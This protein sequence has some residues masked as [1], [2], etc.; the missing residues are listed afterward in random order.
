[1][2]RLQLPLGRK[3]LGR[4][5]PGEVHVAEELW[6]KLHQQ[7][8]GQV[9]SRQAL[10]TICL[11]SAVSWYSGGGWNLAT[12]SVGLTLLLDAAHLQGK[13]VHLAVQLRHVGGERVEHVEHL[14]DEEVDVGVAVGGC[15][16]AASVPSVSRSGAA[17][18]RGLLLGFT[19][20]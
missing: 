18:V 12:I 11:S 15:C 13:Q 5:S 17:V 19:F 7:A 2:Q 14:L 16:G 10:V 3:A 20:L 4:H 6:E 1:M 8:A 9:A